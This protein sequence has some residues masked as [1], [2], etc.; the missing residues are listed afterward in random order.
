[1]AKYTAARK[2]SNQKWDA[3]N[4]DRISVA[5]PKGTKDIVKAHAETRGESM[6]QFILRAITE[7]LARD[8]SGGVSE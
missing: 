4:L 1:M 3:A 7:T 8:Q 6:N 5:L 2:A